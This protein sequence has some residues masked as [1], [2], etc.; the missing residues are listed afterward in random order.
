[1]F[2]D[3]ISTNAASILKKTG[4]LAASAFIVIGM[5]TTVF[6]ETLTVWDD[7]D[8]ESRAAVMTELNA[9]LS[10]SNA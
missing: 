9:L 8:S 5:S 1:M 3:F 2:S 10:N 6:A 7:H 4:I